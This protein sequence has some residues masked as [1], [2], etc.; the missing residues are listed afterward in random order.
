MI[1]GM[2]KLNKKISLCFILLSLMSCGKKSKDGPE[3]KSVIDN[4]V[5]KE[6]KKSYEF[7]LDQA[8][9]NDDVESFKSILRENIIDIN[10]LNNHGNTYLIDAIINK[11]STIRDYLLE[12]GVLIDAS[13]DEGITPLMMA[14]SLNQVE[15]V[16]ILINLNALLD[17]KNFDGD[18]AL[19]LA[20]KKEFET[21]AMMLVSSGANIKITDH[22]NLSAYDL[23]ITRNLPELEELL[24]KLTLVD[25][26]PPDLHTFKTIL[27]NG[28]LST[29]KEILEKYPEIVSTYEVINPLCLSLELKDENTSLQMIQILLE[30]KANPN[31]S[32][33]QSCIPL[34][35]AVKKEKSNIMNLLLEHKAKAHILDSENHSPLIYGIKVN[36]FEI[37]KTLV[38]HKA[39]L[40]YKF[41]SEYGELQKIQACDVAREVEKKL[42]TKKEKK[43]NNRIKALLDCG[44]WDWVF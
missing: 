18:T 25:V 21:I 33:D 39:L 41:I 38:S 1:Q 36:H 23:V 7:D 32:G 11:A 19:H 37:V 42:K 4:S 12:R 29:L 2:K 40:E 30:N 16:Q 15:T 31:G 8:I 20:I 27:Q 17:K 22:D 26:T 34:V 14:T 43:I 10:S 6:E 13:N 9:K 3:T 44:F 35:E 24:K 28:D 5:V